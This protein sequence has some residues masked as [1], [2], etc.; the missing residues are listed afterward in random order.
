MPS[1]IE[2]YN[3]DIFI[4]YRQKDNKYDGWVTEFVDNLKKELE[5]AFKEEISVYFDINPHDGLL[6]THDVDASLKDKLKCLVF[7]PIIS[8][9]YCDPK[10][11]AWEH[12]FKAFVE[13]ATKDQFGLKIKLP[14]GNVTSRVLPVRIYDLDTSD[15][16]LCE[17]V[18][19]GV[20]RSVDFIYKSAGVNRP[21]MSK[22]ENPQ[23]NLNHTNYRDQI[24]K[25]GNAIKEIIA[26]IET[27]EKKLEVV[28]KEDFKPVSVPGKSSNTKTIAGSI[29]GLALIIFVIFFIPKLF[30]SKEPVEKSIAVLPFKLL[31]DEPDKQYL[32]DGMMDAITLHLSKIKD[33]RVMSRTSVEQYQGTT[34]TT[35]QI[36]KELDVE[37][38][39]EGSFQKYGD[40]AKLIVQL[41][42]SNEERH[43]WG[44][45]Y[46][47]KWSEVF[48]LQ[49]EVARSI[50]KE[51]NAVLS[52]EEKQLI[53][54]TPTTSLTAYD[55]YLKANEYKK[56]YSRT[57]N[58]GSYKTAVNLY[59]ASLDID[60]T[61]A[62]A[63]IGLAWAY[64]DRF[65]WPEFFKEYFL[66]SCLV[67]ANKA[68]SIDDKLDEAYYLKGVYYRQNGNIEEA[69]SSFDK[70]I[71]INPN[72]YLAYTAKGSLFSDVLSD[73]RKGLENYH[74]ALTLVSGDERPSILISLGN[75]YLGLGFTD[76]AKYFYQEAFDISNNQL[77]YLW[78]LA[79]MEFSLENYEESLKL[80][81]KRL[82]IDS[83]LLFNL[84]FYLYP[85]GH[86]NEAYIH[87]NKLIERHKRSGTPMYYF[88]HRVGYTFYQMGRLKEADDYLKQQIKYSE[89]SIK[90]NRFY[91]QM[92]H[93]HYDL[94]ATY[95]FLGNK[96]KA[97]KNLDE[98]NTMHYFS[99]G[100]ISFVEN[101]PLFASI[102]SEER[103]QKIVQDMKAKNQ[104]EN[105]RV[106]KWLEEQGML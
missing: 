82:V 11:F 62:K 16:K 53:E 4:S 64:Y 56:E 57:R 30:K 9:T 35:R 95:A 12:E 26:S 49:S 80:L 84:H 6:E 5:A 47:S 23:D 40:D 71:K 3:Y 55:L 54:K 81:K 93:A 94:A 22:E 24:N 25:V 89:E 99:L 14:N 52:P 87:A 1:I 7:I 32:A 58:L 85:P 76:K 15:I 20:L 41:I 8:R 72:Y 50:A 104:A 39:L 31:S 100:F 27:H 28:S 74:K 10:S 21:L 46:S 91:A 88:S 42:K 29:I 68:L 77:Q 48:S 13:L 78:N 65:Y 96:D 45:E 37:Y 36:G 66:D 101:D 103:F 79:N 106:R 38:L 67:L 70:T 51:L 33:L 105:E 69:L 34:K 19:G 44:N 102:R 61:F 83:T 2:G 97:Y 90:L 18:L 98:Y 73:N 86:I 60:S 43:V 59:K 75:I 92:K 17:S 63:Y